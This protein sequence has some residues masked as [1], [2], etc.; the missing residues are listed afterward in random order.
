MPRCA[1]KREMPGCR[2]LVLL[3][4]K[5]RAAADTAG[6]RQKVEIENRNREPERLRQQ[7]ERNKAEPEII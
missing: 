5:G 6:S 7:P 1:F 3:D 2:R 4:G